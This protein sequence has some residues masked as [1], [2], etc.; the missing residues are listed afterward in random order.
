M[1]CPITRPPPRDAE[2]VVVPHDHDQIH[3]AD[4]MLRGIPSQWVLPTEQGGH[5]ITSGAFQPSSDK[6]MGLSLG[7]KK[8]MEFCGKS[9]DE[10][11]AGRFRAV[12]CFPAQELRDQ[13]MKVGWDPQRRG[14][15]PL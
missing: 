7:V 5:R 2:G 8:M 6:Y 14:F 11:A 10:W 1:E 12:V 15:R 13:E 4:V 3:D 9:I